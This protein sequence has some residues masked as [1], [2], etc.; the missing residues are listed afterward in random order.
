[1]LPCHVP[2]NHG[3]HQTWPH[4][5]GAAIQAP[6]YRRCGAVLPPTSARL[7]GPRV[8]HAHLPASTSAAYTFGHDPPANRVSAGDVGAH[9]EE[10]SLQASPSGDKPLPTACS[11]GKCAANSRRSSA[12]SWLLKLR[13][14]SSRD[15]LAPPI[16]LGTPAAQ[17][18]TPAPAATP[19]L[20]QAP[21]PAVRRAPHRALRGP[22]P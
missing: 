12:R 3:A 18:T 1:M 9:L 14:P 13:E 21:A 16:R 19:V 11:G 15:H 22:R 5:F 7:G 10:G 8:A 4:P 20:S 2:S 6:R 17:P